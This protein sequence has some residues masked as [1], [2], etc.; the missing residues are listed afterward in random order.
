MHTHKHN[1]YDKSAQNQNRPVNG[2]RNQNKEEKKQKAEIKAT[3]II[4]TS[5]RSL[6]RLIR[7]D[8]EDCPSNG[9]DRQS[10]RF[11]YSFAQLVAATKWVLF[12]FLLSFELRYQIILARFWYLLMF[13]C[14]QCEMR[15]RGLKLLSI[16]LASRKIR[17]VIAKLSVSW[18]EIETKSER[19]FVHSHTY[20]C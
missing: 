15:E 7:K 20:T 16:S 18:R 10:V 3:K 2:M 4:M 14:D 17:F 5:A 12:F 1:T 6:S 19:W 9:R 13:V 11:V 8:F